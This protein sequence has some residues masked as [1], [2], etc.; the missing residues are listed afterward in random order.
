MTFSG[1]NVD[2]KILYHIKHGIIYCAHVLCINQGGY[3]LVVFICLIKLS[4]DF[5]EHFSALQFI[6]SEQIIIK[7]KQK[8]C[9]STHQFSL[10]K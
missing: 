9:S 4:T 8:L 5:Q 10:I 1:I 6:D 3:G 7:I 2:D